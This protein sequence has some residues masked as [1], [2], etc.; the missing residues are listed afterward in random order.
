MDNEGRIRMISG[1]GEGEF[2]LIKLPYLIYAFGQ[3]D[4]NKQFRTRSDAA[5][6]GSGLHR[7]PLIHNLHTFIGSKLDLLKKKKG[8]EQGCEYFG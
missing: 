8:K 1:V 6:C 3:I 2:G 5:E 7:L 4:L